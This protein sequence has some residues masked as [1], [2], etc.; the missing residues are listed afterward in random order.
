[1]HKIT[2]ELRFDVIVSLAYL[3][4]VLAELWFE[5]GRCKLR[6]L[7]PI[8][9]GLDLLTGRLRVVLRTNI[10]FSRRLRSLI[11]VAKSGEA[12]WLCEVGLVLILLEEL[13]CRLR[14]D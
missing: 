2:G 14:F 4:A 9:I 10:R 8:E 3:R 11:E 13:R 12:F 7:Y 6:N 5:L 1:M